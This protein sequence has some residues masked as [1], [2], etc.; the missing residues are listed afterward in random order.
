M[1]EAAEE[2]V[3]RQVGRNPLAMVSI[4][5]AA[6]QGKSFLMNLLSGSEDMFKISNQR[7]P[8]TQGVDLSRVSQSL[9]EFSCVDGGAQIKDRRTRVVFADAEGQGDRDVR[10]A[11]PP[12]PDPRPLTATG[13]VR[14]SSTTRG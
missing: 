2:T 14:R 10:C 13:S 4:F 7:T 9:S 11:A 3:L 8:C 12:P 5:G 1:D 6:R